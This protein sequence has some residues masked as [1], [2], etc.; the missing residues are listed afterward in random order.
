MNVDRSAECWLAAS[1]G[2]HPSRSSQ[3]SIG[4]AQSLYESFQRRTQLLL[5]AEQ[6]HRKSLQLLQRESSAVHSIEERNE[7][8]A[9]HFM[10]I[11][12]SDL[13]SLQHSNDCVKEES[14]FHETP[15]LR[16]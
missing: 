7:S 12:H 8:R 5:H 14:Y 2:C 11:I 10:L 6:L 13:L 4:K 16:Q 15:L 9:I 3:E 1:I